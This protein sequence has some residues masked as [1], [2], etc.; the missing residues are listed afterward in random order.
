MLQDVD[1]PETHGCDPPQRFTGVLEES[2]GVEVGFPLL[3]TGRPVQRRRELQRRRHHT[4]YPFLRLGTDAIANQE[5]G[6]D[7]QVGTVVFDAAGR[8]Q[9]RHL[10]RHRILHLLGSHVDQI[11]S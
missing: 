7:R 9:H 5:V 3:R 2:L 11:D 10:A 6:A 4:L 8:H 1:A